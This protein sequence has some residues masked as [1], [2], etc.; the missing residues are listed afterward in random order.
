VQSSSQIIITNKPKDI[1]ATVN[2]EWRV[3]VLVT[4]LGRQFTKVVTDATLARIHA[5]IQ[6]RH[7]RLNG[8]V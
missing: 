7:V 5:R 3:C 1:T 8:I 4:S 6:D 2:G